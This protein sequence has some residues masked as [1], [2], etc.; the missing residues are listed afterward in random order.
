MCLIVWKESAKSEFTNRQFKSMI[1]RNSDGLGIMW[2]ENGRVLFEKVL[3]TPK[4]K[5]KM[6]QRHR[7]KE[8]YAMHAR[9]KTHGLIDKHNCHP[10]ELLNID[11]GDPIDLY[12]MHNGVLSGVPETDKDMSDTWHFVE[13]ILKPI[14]KTNLPLLWESDEFHT[15]LQKQIVGSKLLLMRSDNAAEHSTL[16]LNSQAGVNQN[17]CWLSNS[18]STYTAP[19]TNYNYGGNASTKAPFQQ[20]ERTL[21]V[22]TQKQREETLHMKGSTV[23]NGETTEIPTGAGTNTE[24]NAL[25]RVQRGVQLPE[26]FTE[27]NRGKVI[28]FERFRNSLTEGPF[29]IVP[30]LSLYETT[31]LLRG[32]PK[33]E[34]K[35]FIEDDPDLAADIIMAFYEK[36]CMRYEII[37]QQIKDPN[38]V[39]GIVD[40]LHH[41]ASTVDSVIKTKNVN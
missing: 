8:Q 29:T 36:N 2:R 14:A 40:I 38:T 41:V 5:F 13:Y 6:F 31:V 18:Y 35:L 34:L 10:Y 32:L 30:D 3:G 15:W 21:P 22:V 39:N 1:N 33:Y 4:D 12:L 26:A 27:G 25:L 37:M 23:M 24:T 20:Q 11:K 19:H 9:F 17:G 7:D 16:I 28:N